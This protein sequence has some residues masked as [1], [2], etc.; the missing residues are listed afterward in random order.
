MTFK[1]FRDVSMSSRH[2]R[3]QGLGGEGEGSASLWVPL[4]PLDEYSVVRGDRVRVAF[5]QSPLCWASLALT[6][7]QR[8]ALNFSSHLLSVYVYLLRGKPRPLCMLGRN[9]RGWDDG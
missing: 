4:A 7:Y 3:E 9:S 2:N 8:I 1:Y 5:A 6:M